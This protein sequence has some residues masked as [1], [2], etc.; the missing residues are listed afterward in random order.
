MANYP[1]ELQYT[2]DHEWIRITGD[3]GR[4]GITFYAQDSLGDVVYVDLPKVGTTVKANE[5][6]GSVESVK[7]VSELFSPVS[8]E[9]IEVNTKLAD[10]PELVNT[11]PYD[12]GWMIVIR[13]SNPGEVDALLSAAEYEDFINEK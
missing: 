11:S 10:A 5:P 6:F 2:K 9:V 8:G 13:L 4:V 1:D 3:T 7:A 12:E